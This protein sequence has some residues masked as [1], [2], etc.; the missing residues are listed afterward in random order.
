[1]IRYD[2]PWP[3]RATLNHIYRHT[4][5]VFLSEWAQLYRDLVLI[6]MRKFRQTLPEDGWL[7]VR[8]TA[9][10]PD[11]RRRDVANLEKLL[12]DTIF[13]ELGSDDTRIS[14]L[15]LRKR[16]R[17]RGPPGITVIIAPVAMQSDVTEGV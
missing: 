9:Y 6:E 4:G 15:T 3:V 11:K 10:M 2:L 8:I 16:W 1:M 14:D 13:A 17:K 7:E 12:V 5:P